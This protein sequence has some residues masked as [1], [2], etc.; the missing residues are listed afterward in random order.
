MYEILASRCGLTRGSRVLEIGPGT[1][2]ATRRL[3][4]AGA[5][6]VAVEPDPALA[7][8]LVDSALGADVQVVPGLFEEVDLEADAFDL[9]VAATSFHWID[10]VEGLPKVGRVVR[11]GGWVALW[12]TIFGD[13]GRP[14]P[15][16]DATHPLIEESLRSAG[17]ADNPRPPEVA[18]EPRPSGP[19]FELDLEGRQRDLRREVGLVEVEGELVRWTHCMGPAE[20]RALYGSMILLLRLEQEIRDPLLD[21]IQSLAETDFGGVVERPFITSIYTGR[22]PK[23]G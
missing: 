21:R 2:V 1:G 18:E 9:V 10:R 22:R 11:P 6:V 3:L 20:V 14:D 7:D 12:W 4:E 13:R 17:P 23:D 8:Y 5:V 15:F 19:M 16:R